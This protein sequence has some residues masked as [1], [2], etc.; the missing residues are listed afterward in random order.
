MKYGLFSDV[1]G[2]LEAFGEVLDALQAEQVEQYFFLGDIV[3]YGADAKECIHLLKNLV[4]KKGCRCL[5]G[6][7]DY[8]VC[9][10]TPY[11][12]YSRIAQAAI[13]WTKNELD[14]TERDFLS[15]FR[16]KGQGPGFSLVHANLDSPDQWGY[17]LD[18]D[19]ADTNFK[20]LR[21]PICFIGHSHKPI[22]FTADGTVDW[23]IKEKIIL[24]K[25]VRYLI[26]VGSVGQPRDGNPQACYAIY[27]DTTGVI[28]IKRRPYDIAKAQAKI[29]KAGLPKILADRLAF[30][31]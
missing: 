27:D 14:Q 15:Q 22:V 13:E 16:L 17:I 21:D 6:N 12:N 4:D 2:N 5:A 19:D 11:G 23:F 18:I 8:A 28:T 1:H 9:G 24:Q 31:K 10:R 20:I 29:H 25:G 7:H 3:G 30:G 26:N